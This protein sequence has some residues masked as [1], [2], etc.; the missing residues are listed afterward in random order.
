MKLHESSPDTPQGSISRDLKLSKLWLCRELVRLG[1]TEF[2]TVYIL[3]SWYGA[4]GIF[5]LQQHIK[6]D[7]CYCIDWDQEKTEFVRKLALP[8]VR[9]VC[10]DVNEIEYNGNRI[11][12]INTSTNDIEGREWFRSIPK[13]SLVVLQGRDHQDISNGIE[14]LSKFDRV[15]PLRETL[16]VDYLVLTGVEGDVYTRFMKIGFS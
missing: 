11:L 15:Y 4:L 3:G 14:T 1:Q 10:C 7:C 16:L 12:I 2:D 6:F 13:S 5:L 9:A 8:K